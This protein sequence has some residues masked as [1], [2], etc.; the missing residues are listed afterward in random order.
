MHLI[1]LFPIFYFMASSGKI[2]MTEYVL[3][4]MRS[5]IREVITGWLI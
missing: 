5:R 3:E 1:H 4:P 2:D